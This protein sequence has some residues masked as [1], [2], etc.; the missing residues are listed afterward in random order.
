MIDQDAEKLIEKIHG[1]GIQIVFEFAGA[2]SLALDWLHAV[3]GSSRTILE[4]TDRYSARSLDQLLGGVPNKVVEP[5]T[6]AAMARQAYLRACRL[7]DDMRPCVGVACTATIAT[8]YAKRGEHRA[9]VAI[10]TDSSVSTFDLILSKGERDRRGEEALIAMMIVNAIASAAGAAPELALNLVQQENVATESE[11]EAD[12]L[13]LLLS[14]SA[15]LVMVYPDGRRVADDAAPTPGAVIYSGS[16]NPL[17]FGHEAL[18]AAAARVTGLPVVFELPAINA[19][20]SALGRSDLER[21]LEQFLGR[22]PVAV[23]TAPLFSDKAQIF[24]EFIFAIGFDTAVRLVD[25][26]FYGGSE[27]ARDQSLNQIRKQGCRILVAVRR[28]GEKCCAAKDVQIPSGFG[29]LFMELP[30]T[31]F[32]ADISSTE[33]RG[34]LGG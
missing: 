29:D 27:S 13:R 26:R 11:I 33:L 10:Q 4:A 21:R 12:P 31:E 3:A 32:R 24:P 2:G 8:D 18:A 7:G 17:H 20:K 30:E 1:S 28:I 9:C 14:G 34:K 23:T 15:K 22:Y 19:E 6:A 5:R 16:F 25:P